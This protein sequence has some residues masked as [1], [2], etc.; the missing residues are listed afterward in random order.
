MMIKRTKLTEKA[1]HL[2]PPSSSADSP[3]GLSRSLPTSDT[4]SDTMNRQRSH[5]VESG[6]SLDNGDMSV[7]VVDDA[8]HGHGHHPNFP[9]S[10]PPGPNYMRYQQPYPGQQYNE[11]D[12]QQQDENCQNGFSMRRPSSTSSFSSMRRTSMSV[13]MS[14]MDPSYVGPTVG[15]LPLQHHSGSVSPDYSYLD[16]NNSNTTAIQH[17]APP[18][19]YIPVAECDRG[20]MDHF[21]GTVQRLFFPILDLHGTARDAVIQPALENNE[22]YRHCCLSI[23]ALHLKTTQHLSDE[24]LELVDQ[25][26]TRHRYATISGLCDALA[27][28]TDHLQILEA[29]IGMILFQ[30]RNFFFFFLSSFSP[31]DMFADWLFRSPLL[32]F[33]RLPR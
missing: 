23:A 9:H 21:L 5:S 2:S 27:K 17:E 7:G 16:F 3:P 12:H 29:T 11:Y 32:V 14:T 1:V 30:V 6:F 4:L 22:C 31:P 28:D 20:L 15:S 18:T 19:P 24:H 26:I 13:P 10:M 33:R 8:F 25:D